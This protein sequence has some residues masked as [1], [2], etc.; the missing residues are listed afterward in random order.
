MGQRY[1]TP[2]AFLAAVEQ[3]LRNQ[4]QETGSSLERS[5]Q[6]LVFDRFLARVRVIKRAGGAYD[7]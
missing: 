6:L 1:T 5:R 2:A 3:R 7:E 4:A